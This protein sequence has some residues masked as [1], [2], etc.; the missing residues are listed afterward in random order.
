M[1]CV[2]LKTFNSQIGKRGKEEKRNVQNNCSACT[3]RFFVIS[4][5]AQFTAQLCIFAKISASMY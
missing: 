5:V 4:I 1:Q 2:M 3:K